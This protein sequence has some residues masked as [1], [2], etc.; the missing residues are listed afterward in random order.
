M[1]M[2]LEL[3]QA[4][5]AFLGG[6]YQLY[7]VL[8]TAHA[9]IMIFFFVMPTAIGG[10][11]NW[12]VPIMIGACDMAFE[13]NLDYVNYKRT[14]K[15]S[16]VENSNLKGWCEIFFSLRTETSLKWLYMDYCWCKHGRHLHGDISVLKIFFSKPKNSSLLNK[17]F[18]SSYSLIPGGNTNKL[19]Y[20]PFSVKT[21]LKERYTQFEQKCVRDVIVD[22]RS[23][24]SLTEKIKNNDVILMSQYHNP[25]LR[26]SLFAR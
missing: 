8:V 16:A 12:F 25:K 9:F 6:N 26:P 15:V 24:D 3:S 14:P 21:I 23:V 2:R 17:S 19:N 5:D 18:I 10:F 7:N 22:G 20:R 1:A 13:R 11:G 4:G